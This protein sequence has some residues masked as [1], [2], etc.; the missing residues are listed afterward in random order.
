VVL[1]VE[2]ALA[3]WA[4]LTDPYPDAVADVDVRICL[5]ERDQIMG[6]P[7]RPWSI[8]G[9]PVGVTIEGWPSNIARLHFADLFRDLFPHLAEF[10]R[11]S[12]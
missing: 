10:G 5:D 3:R 11:N 8:S 12:E 6:P 1:E 7:P 4:G 9:G 2:E